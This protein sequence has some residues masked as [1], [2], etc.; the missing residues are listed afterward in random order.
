[1]QVAVTIFLDVNNPD[2]FRRAAHDRAI[3]DGLGDEEASSYLEAEETSL[4]QC[5]VMLLDPGTSPNGSSIIDSATT[6]A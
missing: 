4:G 2:D 3:A 5:A 6:S 1:M